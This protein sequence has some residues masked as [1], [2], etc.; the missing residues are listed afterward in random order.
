MEKSSSGGA[1]NQIKTGQRGRRAGQTPRSWDR[2]GSSPSPVPEANTQ[3]MQVMCKVITQPLCPPQ[4]HPRLWISVPT[5]VGGTKDNQ[6]EIHS[7]RGG[8]TQ[9]GE[10]L[11]NQ[12]GFIQPRGD[13]LRSASTK[14]K[15]L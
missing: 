15:I 7:T 3:G 6:G 13:L 4:N 10:D 1:P 11:L 5:R 12:G 9:P 14:S 2:E 8:F